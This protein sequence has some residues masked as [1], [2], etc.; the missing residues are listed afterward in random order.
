MKAI[1]PATTTKPRTV[2][3]TITNTTTK[4][5]VVVPFSLKSDFVTVRDRVIRMSAYLAVRIVVSGGVQVEFIFS[6]R[7]TSINTDTVLAGVSH[8]YYDNVHCI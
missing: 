2:T 7:E 3:S 1:R 5:T 6:A 4:T 8:W